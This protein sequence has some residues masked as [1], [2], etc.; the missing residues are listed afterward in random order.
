MA[1]L[2]LL[3]MAILKW[4]ICS[5][6]FCVQWR[7]WVVS[8]WRW[9]QRPGKPDGVWITSVLSFRPWP[10]SQGRWHVFP[11]HSA[12]VHYSQ[13]KPWA[14]GPLTDL[15]WVLRSSALLITE[16]GIRRRRRAWRSLFKVA[17][18]SCQF[19]CPLWGGD[20]LEKWVLRAYALNMKRNRRV[21]HQQFSCLKI[22]QELNEV[23]K[24]F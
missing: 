9:I 12:L 21:Y 13:L 8:K 11:D 14:P 5:V 16:L 1:T 22:F 6:I 2:S 7:N 23:I 10:I 20:C 18:C 19:S 3:H 17:E 24:W 15:L 4:Q